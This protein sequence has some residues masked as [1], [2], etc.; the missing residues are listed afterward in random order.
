MKKTIK[1]IGSSVAALLMGF[2]ACNNVGAV[3]IGMD[4]FN[5][6]IIDHANFDGGNNIIRIF[7]L[8]QR[9]F[10]KD[11]FDIYECINSGLKLDPPIYCRIYGYT[12]D[13]NMF[14]NSSFSVTYACD[15]FRT[16]VR[17]ILIPIYTDK[18]N[19]SEV[20]N[21]AK[22]LLTLIGQQSANV[23]QNLQALRRNGEC[24][25]PRDQINYRPY[26]VYNYLEEITSILCKLSELEPGFKFGI[27][28]NN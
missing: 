7:N 4:D 16:F 23:L 24:S 11:T 3:R 8:I 28:Q 21:E 26:M 13:N 17:N 14:I 10:M 19:S 9:D 18:S 25:K 27:N 20:L 1:Q 15:F 2:S 12:N 6:K 5:N 22:F